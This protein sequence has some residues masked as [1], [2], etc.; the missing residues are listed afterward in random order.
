MRIYASNL[1]YK[2][3]NRDFYNLFA[4]FGEVH[5]IKLIVNR[6]TG[7]SK[8]YG[9]ADMADDNAEL[10]I[11]LLNDSVLFGRKIFVTKSKYQ[12]D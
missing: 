8:G 7:Y 1:P 12:D 6:D 5:N 2:I 9:F 4:Q 10:A 11:S 3:T